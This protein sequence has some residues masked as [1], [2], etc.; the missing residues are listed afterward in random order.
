MRQATPTYLL[1]VAL[2]L[3]TA[4][5][6]RADDDGTQPGDQSLTCDQV[7]TQVATQNNIVNTQGALV[8]Q[9]DAGTAKS[10]DGVP[11]VT[12]MD[13]AKEVIAQRKADAATARGHALVKLGQSKK[14]FK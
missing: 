12:A 4:V 11:A 1:I 9:Y 2:L 5:S 7:T 6:A 13:H 3:G 10:V 8:Q 14:C